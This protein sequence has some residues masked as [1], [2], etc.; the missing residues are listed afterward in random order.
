M[1]GLSQE[2]RCTFQSS[3]GEQASLELGLPEPILPAPEM[4]A[5]PVAIMPRLN[6]IHKCTHHTNSHRTLRNVEHARMDGLSSVEQ[7]T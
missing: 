7:K 5:G 4:C 1:R 2:L 3:V 6:T